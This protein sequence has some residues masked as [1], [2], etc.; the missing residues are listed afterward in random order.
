MFDHIA[1]HGCFH[2]KPGDEP[3][4]ALLQRRLGGIRGLRVLEPGC[5]SG[6]LTEWLA[7]W[8]EPG[9]HVEA[10]DPSAG[11]LAQAAANLRGVTNVR[12]SR[13]RCEEA[14]WPPASFD[15]VLCFRVFPHFDDVEAVLARFHRWLAPEGRLLIVHWEGRQAL[16]A[17]HAHH[18]P[19]DQDVFPQ[20]SYLESALRRRRFKIE[21]WIEDENEIYVEATRQDTSA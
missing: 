7:R 9:G 10:F 14:D 16:N 18:G 12:L 2:F 15:I 13:R 11:M 3:R 8:V 5:G 17:L 20:R 6:P 1:G 19:V 4:L 21:R